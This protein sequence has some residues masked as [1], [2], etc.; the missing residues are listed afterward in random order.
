ME[1]YFYEIPIY[2]CTPERHFLEL[3][4]LENKI[5]NEIG[6]L[7]IDYPENFEQ[8]KD[9]RYARNSYPFDYNEI[10]GWI[11][12]YILGN[13]IRGEYYFE[14]DT[15]DRQKEKKRLDKGI[16]KKRFEN[17]GK[18]FEI[19]IKNAT[20]NEQI[21][22]KLKNELIDLQNNEKPFKGRF[23]D[24]RQLDNITEFID[25]QGLIKALNPLK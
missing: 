5:V 3:G 22:K 6:I 9:S 20:D 4:E 17:F 23:I 16:R 10:I 25:W 15:K 7:S 14:V 12:L 2:R 1:N 13:Q 19:S 11:K 24:T 18:A 8:I 21:S